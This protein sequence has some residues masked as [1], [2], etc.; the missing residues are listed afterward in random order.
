MSHPDV[1]ADPSEFR[2]DGDDLIA[3]DPYT[4][5]HFHFGMLL[6]V[7]DFETEQAY[8]R[9]KHC[10]HQAWMHGPGVVWGRGRAILPL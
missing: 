1:I 6:G 3:D 10:L 5:L 4:A 9:A 2:C 7:D 8:H